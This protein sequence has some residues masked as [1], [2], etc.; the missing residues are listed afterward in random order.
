MT[1][2]TL[3]D[4]LNEVIETAS[5]F[6]DESSSAVWRNEHECT[7]AMYECAQARRLFDKTEDAY[8]KLISAFSHPKFGD[9]IRNSPIVKHNLEAADAIY[10]ASSA[11]FN[12]AKSK[13]YCAQSTYYESDVWNCET[14][15]ALEEAEAT[16]AIHFP[17]T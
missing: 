12:I 5:Y 14:K 9:Q 17:P 1:N 16:Y 6:Y 2:S 7:L 4:R 15:E 11:M 13:Y 10:R 3:R 8:F